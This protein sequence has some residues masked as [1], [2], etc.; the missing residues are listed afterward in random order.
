M[1]RTVSV[2]VKALLCYV[3]ESIQEYVRGRSNLWVVFSYPQH[4][5]IKP[6]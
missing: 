2:S 1:R 5:I 3:T 6:Q 4:N